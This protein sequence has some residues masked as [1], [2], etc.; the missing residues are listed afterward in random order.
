MCKPR[1]SSTC[2]FLLCQSQRELPKPPMFF[3]NH[4]ENWLF[5]KSIFDMCISDDFPLI[6]TKKCS[7]C[8]S[9]LKIV[10]PL[11]NLHIIIKKRRR[12]GGCTRQRASPFKR[13]IASSLLLIIIVSF[14]SLRLKYVFTPLERWVASA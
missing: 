5:S 9:I 12:S 1:H 13:M 14:H 4:R 10:M 2:V 11:R 8:D 6:V 3:Q 7:C